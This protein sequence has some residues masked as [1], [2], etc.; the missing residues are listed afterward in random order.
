MIVR[1]TL[2][3]IPAARLV[4]IDPNAVEWNERLKANNLKNINLFKK[5]F[6]LY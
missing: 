2:V 6:Y 5:A 4:H 3:C 1:L